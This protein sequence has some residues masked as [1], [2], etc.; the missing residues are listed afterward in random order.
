MCYDDYIM[1]FFE[2]YA[3]VVSSSAHGIGEPEK[4][5]KENMP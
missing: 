3:Y 2:E 4:K 1:Y 5:R